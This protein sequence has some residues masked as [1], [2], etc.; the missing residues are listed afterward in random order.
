[1]F[2]YEIKSS[3]SNIIDFSSFES[4]KHFSIVIDKNIST[5][6]ILKN[7]AFAEKIDFFV[8]KNSKIVVK[9]ITNTLNQYCEIKALVDDSA[10]IDFYI[11]DLVDTNVGLKANIVLYGENAS[12]KWNLSC[13]SIKNNIKKYTISFNHLGEKSISNMLNYGV[14]VGQSTLIFD[15]S[16]HIEKMANESSASQ[17][18]KIIVYDKECKA[19]ANPIL[20]IDNNNISANHAAAVGTLNEEHVFYLLSRGISERNARKLITLG[21][22]T[23]IFDFFSDDEK[24]EFIKLIEESI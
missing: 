6:L 13:L 2:L 8:N 3:E 4:E 10:S 24:S 18:A 1:M 14:S 7:V 23:P 20:K 21:Y 11:V 15:G 12:S 9:S 22:L 16:S 5:T 19:K 17:K